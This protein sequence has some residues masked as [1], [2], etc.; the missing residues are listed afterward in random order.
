MTDRMHGRCPE[1]GVVAAMEAAVFR[2]PPCRYLG[3]LHTRHSSH[4]LRT[5]LLLHGRDAVAVP[6]LADVAASGFVA[7]L[8]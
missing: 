2:L 3:D 6:A 1:R 4:A 8:P 7:S 5:G